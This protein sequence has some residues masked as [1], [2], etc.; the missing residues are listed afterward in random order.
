MTLHSELLFTL[1]HYTER[2]VEDL[3]SRPRDAL[4]TTIYTS[5]LPTID[6][7]TSFEFFSRVTETLIAYLEH[8]RPAVSQRML[9]IIQ[10]MIGLR[11]SAPAKRK[12]KNPYE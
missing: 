8:D 2:V 7:V 10:R 12:E 11:P 9:E 5:L 4:E 3:A 1:S 6:H